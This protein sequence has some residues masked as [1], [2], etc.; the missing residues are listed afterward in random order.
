MSQKRI[1]ITF[2]DEGDPFSLDIRQCL[3]VYDVLKMAKTEMSRKLGQYD[4]N[5]LELRGDGKSF[6]LDDHIDKLPLSSV[7][8][9]FVKGSNVAFKLLERDIDGDV[10]WIDTIVANQYDMDKLLKKGSYLIATDET[11]HAVLSPT[12]KEYRE[13]D[14]NI[15]YY[16][17]CSP[18]SFLKT[19]SW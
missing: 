10:V 1:K 6:V 3:T 19:V 4:A 15:Q 16:E 8:S 11:G 13:L 18:D 5:D 7:F 2:N 14:P 17:M 12:I 9:V